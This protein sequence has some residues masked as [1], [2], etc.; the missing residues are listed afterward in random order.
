MIGSNLYLLINPPE[1]DR[2]GGEVGWGG[3]VDVR[4][5]VGWDG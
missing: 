4:G 2:S 3:V 1:G 5:G